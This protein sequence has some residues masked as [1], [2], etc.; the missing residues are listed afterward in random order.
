V[1]DVRYYR[2]RR[3]REW[4]D[5][6]LWQQAHIARLCL[7]GGHAGTPEES[8]PVERVLVAGGAL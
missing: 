8:R 3:F 4:R 2:E 6:V 7:E 1:M 5:T